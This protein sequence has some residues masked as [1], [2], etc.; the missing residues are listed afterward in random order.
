M[1]NELVVRDVLS[2]EMV[3]VGREFVAALDRSNLPINAALWIFIAE[4]SMWRFLV[5]S[6]QV[7]VRGPKEVYS[8]IQ[9]I[10]SNMPS[11]R[12]RIAIQNISVVEP[13]SPLVSLLSGFTS[14]GPGITGIR[15]S[16]NIINGVLIEDAYIYRLYREEN[17]VPKLKS[18][19]N[20]RPKSKTKPTK[21][22]HA[23]RRVHG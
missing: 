15:F 6:S 9:T 20:L 23:Q 5:A 14:T 11:D 19:Q 13:E 7:V 10:L 21:R 22:R 1:D 12:A 3:V 18:Q 17:S 8:R 16:Q 2:E 4:L